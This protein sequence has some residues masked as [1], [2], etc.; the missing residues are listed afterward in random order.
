MSGKEDT[1]NQ[2]DVPQ[3]SERKYTDHQKIKKK[4]TESFKNA[5]S[6]IAK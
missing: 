2:E 3:E 5:V 6:S 1:A 4:K